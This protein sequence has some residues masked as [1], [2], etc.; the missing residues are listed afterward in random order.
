MGS[1]VTAVN[2]RMTE[3]VRKF[4]ERT[5]TELAHMRAA[6]ALLE[7]GDR[8]GLS[9]L[10]QWAHRACGT[11]GTLGLLGLS[12]AAGELERRV[13]ACVQNGIP[14]AAQRAQLCAGVDAVAAQL[15]VLQERRD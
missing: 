11:G 4:V 15:A 3:L 5:G 8:S 12:D 2:A 1:Q 13:E 14:D 6:L 9:Q 7:A 10:H